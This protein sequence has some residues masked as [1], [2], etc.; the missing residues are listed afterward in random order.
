[1]WWPIVVDDETSW[2]ILVIS[3]KTITARRS[4]KRRK[5]RK[6]KKR[7]QDRSILWKV[8]SFLRLLIIMSSGPTVNR[9]LIKTSCEK[10]RKLFTPKEAMQ[11]YQDRYYHP[12]CFCCSVCG[13]SIAGKAF[14][15]KPNNQYQCESCNTNLAPRWNYSLDVCW[16]RFDLVYFSFFRLVVRCVM[17]KFQQE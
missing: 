2:V 8:W 9:P 3:R 7:P 10:C 1:M 15:P 14:Y 5:K 12:D 6:G 11:I 16:L 13:K 4:V 17:K